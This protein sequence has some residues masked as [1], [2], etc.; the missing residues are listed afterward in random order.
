MSLTVII[1]FTACMAFIFLYSLVQLSLVI[2]YK[3]SEKQELKQAVAPET[4]PHVTVQL[5]VYNEYYVIEGLIDSVCNFDYPIDKLE[6]QVLDDSND[7][8]IELIKNKISYYQKLGF[9][10]SHVRRNDRVGYKAGAL[11][12]GTSICKGEFIAIFDADFKPDQKFLKATVPHF[13]NENTG[14]V[15]T[16]WGYT[17]SKYSTLTQLQEFGLNAH[18]SIE[19]VGRNSGQ[20]FINFNGTAGVWRK[21]CIID[22][23]GWESD[24][25]TEDLDLSYRAQLRNWKFIYLEDVISPSELPI[26]INA[27]KAQQ[28]RWTK[29]AAEC[30]LKNFKSVLISGNIKFTTKVH[31][32]FHLMN[33]S[34]FLLILLMAILSLPVILAKSEL[35]NTVLIQISSVFMFSWLI[36]GLFYYTSFKKHSNKSLGHF[37]LK[38][39]SFLA[40]SMGLSLHNSMAV[41]EGYFGRK[42]PFIRTPKFNINEPNQKWEN[43]IYRVKKI[44]SI[45]YFEGILLIY[46]LY[47]LKVALDHHD[48][49]MIP[50]LCFLIC[51]YAFVFFSSIIHLNR[52]SRK[53]IVYEKAI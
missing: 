10:I 53:K 27:L 15:Q 45:T 31:A 11:K 46:F 21:S 16:K 8:T 28:Y 5:P 41:L 47:A 51:G 1:I 6:I 39:I 37:F 43:N 25:L 50:F 32:L 13:K 20:H 33:S 40:V 22:A 42:T 4:W 49:A 9:D 30:F 29:G 23:G 24:T 35:E 48:Y 36:L 17:N 44:S 18:F 26:E 2:N 52:A 12:Y 19:Q 3:N 34:V 38:F 7:E 14:V